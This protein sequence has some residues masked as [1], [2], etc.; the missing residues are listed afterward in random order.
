VLGQLGQGQLGQGLLGQGL[1]ELGQPRLGQPRLVL[2]ELVL[3]EFAV[4]RQQHSL[5]R[6]QAQPTL[7]QM[8]S[9]SS[10]STA[11]WSQL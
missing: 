7:D 9:A 10:Y 11:S 1:L 5:K 6:Q 2:P 4:R 8:E 3:K